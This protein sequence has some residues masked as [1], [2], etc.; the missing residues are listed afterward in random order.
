MILWNCHGISYCFKNTFIFH[1]WF[2]SVFCNSTLQRC[3]LSTNYYRQICKC[4]FFIKLKRYDSNNALNNNLSNTDSWGTRPSMSYQLLKF[5]SVR[6]LQQFKYFSFKDNPSAMLHALRFL[7]RRL[8]AD[9]TS[10]LCHDY[11][12]QNK[13]WWVEWFFKNSH[14]NW[15]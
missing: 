7:I 4:C 5:I 14:N 6:R 11:N 8:Q 15:I 2:S 12:I 9:L 13:A 1:F 3:I 10:L